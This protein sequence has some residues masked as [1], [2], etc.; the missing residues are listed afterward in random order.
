MSQRDDQRHPSGGIS[1]LFTELT[2]MRDVGI[3][4][5]EHTQED[6]ERTHASAWVPPTDIVVQGDDLL[7]RVELS[8]VAPD[9]VHLALHRGVLTI[10]GSRSS[11]LEDTD[12]A[13]FYVRERF[14]GEF[15]RSFTLA[16]S[17]QPDQISADFYYG[18]V[19]IVVRDGVSQSAATR[20]Q[21]NDRSAGATTRTLS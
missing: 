12:P 8:G 2:R 10:S 14:Y 20:I 1:D 21:V 9:E 19:E 7:I 6:R 13:S 17:T 15:R 16:E 18:L 3:H 5:R 11:G 4:G